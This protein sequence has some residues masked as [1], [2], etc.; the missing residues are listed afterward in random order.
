MRAN[1]MSES[2]RVHATW[3]LF[4]FLEDGKQSL[5]FDY[6]INLYI[7]AYLPVEA[8]TR[9]RALC[10]ASAAAKCWE[11]GSR[12]RSAVSHLCVF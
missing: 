9:V 7:N 2:T 5:R 8:V 11:T 1:E 10:R 3:G 4:K 6:A 12:R